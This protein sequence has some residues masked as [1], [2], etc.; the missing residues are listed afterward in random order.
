MQDRYA[1]AESLPPIDPQ[2]DWNLI[3]GENENGFTTLEF[4][5]KWVTCDE[6]DRD[7]EV[8]KEKKG[9]NY[10]VHETLITGP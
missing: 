2:Q 5:R 7:I 6:R 4:S 8:S 3:R 1:D 10:I 9:S